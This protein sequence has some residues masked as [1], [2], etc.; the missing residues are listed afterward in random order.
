MRPFKYERAADVAS[1]V[2][3]VA[4]RPGAAFLAGGTNLVDHM[5]LG[6]VSPDLLVDV[7]RL[8]LNRVER[9][10][11]G[12]VRIGAGVRNSDLAADATI[13]TRY[14]ARAP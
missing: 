9:R 3:R 11:G 8:P 7:T 1:A 5:K 2:A 10:E 6:V 13:R 12:V 14:P 4:G